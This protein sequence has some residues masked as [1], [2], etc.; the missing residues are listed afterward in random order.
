MNPGMTRAA[1]ATVATNRGALPSGS[2]S[3]DGSGGD[4]IDRTKKIHLA[5][6][7]AV[8][9][10][11]GIGHRNMKKSIGDRHLQQVVLAT[12]DLAGRPGEFDFAL[13]RA[14]I[15]RLIHAFRESNGLPDARL[16]VTLT[17]RGF[18]GEALSIV[19]IF[20]ILA[21]ILVG[22][23]VAIMLSDRRPHR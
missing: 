13:A 2:S 18:W 17:R 10:E 20:V 23:V 1:A 9:A 16:P 15:L 3:I 11:D 14:R 5:D 22:G 7:D 8:V 19:L 12:D 21:V 6:V 4:E